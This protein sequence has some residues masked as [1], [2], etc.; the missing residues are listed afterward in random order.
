M[1][2]AKT[3]NAHKKAAIYIRCLRLSKNPG[4]DKGPQPLMALFGFGDMCGKSAK[5]AC[6]ARLSLH[7]VLAAP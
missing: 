4:V 6:V 7:E 3:K 5:G 1:M 2:N